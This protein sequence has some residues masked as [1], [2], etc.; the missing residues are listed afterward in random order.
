MKNGRGSKLK[1]ELKLELN[2]RSSTKGGWRCT[3]S[4][5][6]SGTMNTNV[7]QFLT[8]KATGG[9]GSSEITF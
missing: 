9:G 6:R 2:F 1:R 5:A 4:A 3:E 7:H 8:E